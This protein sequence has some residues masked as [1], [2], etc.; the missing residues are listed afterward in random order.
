[1]APVSV[2]AATIF[3]VEISVKPSRSS[4]RRNPASDAAAS[5]NFA[6][7]RGWR[8]ATGAKSRIVGN[9]SFSTGRRNSTGGGSAGCEST[10]NDGP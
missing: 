4:A 8:S 9:V 1:L 5:S 6:R 3:G 2:A 10:Q 7:S